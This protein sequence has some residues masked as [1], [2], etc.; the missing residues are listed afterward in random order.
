MTRLGEV[1]NIKSGYIYFGRPSCP[2]CQIFYPILQLAS[3]RENKQIWYFNTDYFRTK[4][5]LPEY[6][7]LQV[8]NKYKISRVPML[9]YVENGKIIDSFGREIT[10]NK[11]KNDA[12]KGIRRDYEKNT[13]HDA[14]HNTDKQYGS[15][16][17][18]K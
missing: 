4:K 13:L 3:L 18:R 2:S 10:N 11:E 7:I 9:I 8:C 6:E 5:K 1:E 12:Y 15:D 14:C 16:R 17:M